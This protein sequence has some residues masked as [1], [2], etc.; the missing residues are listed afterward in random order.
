MSKIF[1]A[2]PSEIN[3]KRDPLC[4]YRFV[5]LWPATNESKMYP[6]EN[7]LGF[8]AGID[9]DVNCAV[10]LHF[11]STKCQW[12]WFRPETSELW[13]YNSIFDNAYM[14]WFFDRE[15]HG[16]YTRMII[17]L[18]WTHELNTNK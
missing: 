3:K 7:S 11:N 13:F 17:D 15:V 9:V 2:Y 12:E 14:E 10:L 5:Q 1:K 18:P 6:C 8:K 16:K 4:G